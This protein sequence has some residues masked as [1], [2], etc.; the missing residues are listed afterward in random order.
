MRGVLCML[1]QIVQTLIERGCN[2]SV[3]NNDGYTASDLAYSLSLFS[4]FLTLTLHWIRIW[5]WELT[6][7]AIMHVLILA[8]VRIR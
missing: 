8:I 1:V 3:R 2:Y 5:T 7:S 4:A 6:H